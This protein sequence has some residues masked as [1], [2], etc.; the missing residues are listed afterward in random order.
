M[1][2]QQLHKF[3]RAQIKKT[4][5]DIKDIDNDFYTRLIANASVIKELFD[6]LYAERDTSV[7]DDLIKLLITSYSNRSPA[8]KEKDA[9]KSED[10]FLS[11]NLAGMSLYVDRFCTNLASLPQKLPYLTN[12][13][14]NVLHLMPLFESP[15]GES[16]GGY[17]VSHFR[18]VD[19][20][21]GSN[22][23]LLDLIQKMHMDGMYLMLDIVLNH[24]SHRHPWAQKAKGGDPVY[25][26]FYYTFQDRHLPDVYDK[27]MPE[28]F[29]ESAPGN[30]TY[31]PEM[32]RW[33]MTVFH[34]YQ[35]DLNFRNPQVLLAMLENIFFYANTGVDILR[36]DAPAF[37]WKSPGTYSN[38]PSMGYAGNRRYKSNVGGS[39]PYF[40]K[41]TKHF[42]DHLHP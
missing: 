32:N 18:T 24:T 26:N 22:E 9:Q 7:F 4:T 30:F 6:E 37:I 31:S 38:G 3:I 5:L 28:I 15:P 2:H 33:V 16:D 10:W 36:I 39:A 12:L 20:R 25:Q 8:L 13:G 27:G 35:W 29:P 34:N 42:L 19:A 1:Y 41:A 40:T 11:N 23:D 14:V 21:F 17:A